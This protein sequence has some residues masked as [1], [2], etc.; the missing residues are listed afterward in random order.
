M[1]EENNSPP[2]FTFT[3][4]VKTSLWAACSIL[5]RPGESLL[6]SPAF[7]TDA[8]L[9][10]SDASWTAPLDSWWVDWTK[11]NIDFS[12]RCN[13]VSA[14]QRSAEYSTEMYAWCECCPLSGRRPRPIKSIM[15]PLVQ[16]FLILMCT[17]IYSCIA[18][19]YEVIGCLDTAAE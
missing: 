14:K 6:S 13:K 17:I 11:L 3:S 9:P 19:R 16:P 2:S 7:S 8:S 5:Q 10:E 4:Q 15:T 12:F 1:G 18:R